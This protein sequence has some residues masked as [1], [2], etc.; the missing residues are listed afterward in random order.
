MSNSS[1]EKISENTPIDTPSSQ[2]C[3]KDG[4]VEHAKPQTAANTSSKHTK[5]GAVEQNTRCTAVDV[6]QDGNN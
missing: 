1:T 4:F 3:G 6:S 2:V 5:E